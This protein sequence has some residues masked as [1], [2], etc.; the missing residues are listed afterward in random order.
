LQSI[1]SDFP[2]ITSL[3]SIGN[4]S[5]APA[6][7]IYGLKV[8][9]NP[10]VDEFEPEIQVTGGVHGNEQLSCIMV[11]KLLEYITDN[12]GVIQEITDLVDSTEI[13]FF[14]VVNPYGLSQDIRYNANFVDINRNFGWAW[15]DQTYHGDAPFDQPESQALRDDA[16]ERPYVFSFYGHTGEACINTLWDYIGTTESNGT[17]AAYTY[18]YFLNNY[19]PAYPFITD[20]AQT[21]LDNVNTAGDSNFWMTEGYEWYPVYGSIQDWLYGE[22]GIMAFT[23]EYHITKNH[24]EEDEDLFNEIFDYHR[25]AFLDIF[26]YAHRGV[27]GR[28]L[29]SGGLPVSAKVWVYVPTKE[30]GDRAYDDP[31]FYTTFGYTDAGAGDYHIPIQPGT[32]TVEI[33]ADGYVTHTE[34]NVVVPAGDPWL[35]VLDDVQLVPGKSEKRVPRTPLPLDPTRIPPDLRQE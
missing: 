7:P 26:E 11:M 17:P 4:S 22:R 31:V 16:I 24:T 29:G 2:G 12:Y 20:A 34:S 14:P 30:T 27:S 13:H 32:Y 33:E 9:D 21:Y 8:T 15:V 23:L 19:L 18:Q 35:C 6:Y 3:R 25:Q 1:A 10:G 28:V 5:G